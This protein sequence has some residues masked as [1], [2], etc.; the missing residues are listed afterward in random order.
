M[1][2]LSS[3]YLLDPTL[4]TSPKPRPQKALSCRHPCHTWDVGLGTACE[5]VSPNLHALS[6]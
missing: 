4:N 2:R 5:V 6:E 3:S 1:L